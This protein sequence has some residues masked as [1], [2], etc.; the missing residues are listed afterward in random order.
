MSLK[1]KIQFLIIDP[2]N[3]FCDPK[4]ELFVPGS[5]QDVPRLSHLLNRIRSKIYGIS[6]S[7][8]SHHNIHISHPIMFRDSNGEQPKPFTCITA[9]DLEVGKWTTRIPSHYKRVLEYLQA[10]EKGGRY[11]HI[12]WPP[13]CLIGS[14]GHGVD[15]TI[16][17]SL[18]EWEEEFHM[19][20]FVTKGSGIWTEHFSAVKAE[21]PDPND[22]TTQINTNFISTL[23]LADEIVVSGQALSHCVRHTFKDIVD[24]FSD[25][26]TIK[27]MVLLE[28]CSSSVPGFE[29]EGK[30]FIAEIKTLGAR[31][32]TSDKYL[33]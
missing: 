25:P 11:P 17:K 22:P 6:V 13:H 1:R 16:Y 33:I 12:I 15:P 3:S 21:V 9:K 8:D 2:Q 20:D 27:K 32:T 24:N 28:D 14:F 30:D 29:K 23:E 4:G 26:N 7:L 19:V 18:L 31:V 10:L 5:D